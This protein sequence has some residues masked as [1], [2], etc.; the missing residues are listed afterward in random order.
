MIHL[1]HDLN[2]SGVEFLIT[3]LQVASTF[4]E[5]AEASRLEETKYRNHQNARHAYDSVVVFLQKLAINSR[6]RQTIEAN[7]AL[8]KARLEAAGE[9]F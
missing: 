3:D 1:L 7:L 8:L 9:Q 5:V 4:M 2:R 6:E